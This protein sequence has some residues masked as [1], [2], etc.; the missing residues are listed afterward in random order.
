MTL[1]RSHRSHAGRNEPFAIEK[2]PGDAGALNVEVREK[3][4]F[5]DDWPV[6]VEFVIHA[7][8]GGLCPLTRV[9]TSPT[10][11]GVGVKCCAASSW[12]Q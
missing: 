12:N 5:R 10:K 3:S 1:L 6:P 7:D 2:A 8:Q 4:V 9:R 11:P